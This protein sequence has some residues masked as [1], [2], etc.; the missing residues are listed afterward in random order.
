ME[1]ELQH[2]FGYLAKYPKDKIP[3]D[4]ADAP[5]R[6]EADFTTGQQWIEFYPDASEDIPY[7]VF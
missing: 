3:I 6:K 4:I 2:V 7:D 5:I 1:E